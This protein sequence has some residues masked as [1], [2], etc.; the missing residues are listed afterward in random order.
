MS[1]RITNEQIKNAKRVKFR[2]CTRDGWQTATR[3]I[4]G[5][6]ENEEFVYVKFNGWNPF[7]L[8]FNEVIEIIK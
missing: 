1:K 3:D 6:S 4:I 2:V 8:R 5:F 7:F